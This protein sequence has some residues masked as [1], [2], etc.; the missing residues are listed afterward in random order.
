MANFITLARI[1]LLFIG[2]GFIY[3][4]NLYG[5]IIAFFIILA[6][7]IMDWLDGY[8]ARRHNNVTPFGAV[9]DIMADRIVENCLWIV[10]AHLHIIPVWVPLVVIV[11]GFVTD[12][13]R[14]VALTKGRTPFGEK[15]MIKS[16]IGKL[17]VSSRASRALYGA[18]KVIT[19]CYLIFYLAFIEVIKKY[20][21][22]TYLSW[23]DSI[24]HIGIILVY[25]TVFFCIIRAIPVVL[26][27]KYYFQK[28]S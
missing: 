9:F 13:L 2:I 25:I 10:F 26:D 22:S 21:L 16:Y 17:L 4:R 23:H 1:I 6:V 27:S 11:R 19:F 15:T 20:P 7:I 18:V 24:Y 8:V 12:T 14:S 5:E 28:E 3:T